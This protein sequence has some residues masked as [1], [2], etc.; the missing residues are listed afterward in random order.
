MA[1]SSIAS[2][3][4]A[5][6][7]PSRAAAG[8]ATRSPRWTASTAR[9][10]TATSASC[11]S[12]SPSCSSARRASTGR[13]TAR[14]PP[15][16]C[17]ATT[18]RA[19]TAIGVDHIMWG[20]DYPHM[21]GTFPFSRE[22][23]QMTFEGVPTTRSRRCSAATPPRIYGFDLD[24]LAPIAAECGP[25][26]SDVDA[27]LDRVPEGAREHGVLQVRWCRTS[28]AGRIRPAGCSGC[29]GT[30][31]SGPTRCLRACSRANF[32]GPNAGLD[33]A[34]AL[35]AD[36]VEVG[37]PG[38]PRLHR[39]RELACVRDVAARSSAGSAHIDR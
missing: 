10:P 15:A 36:E 25:L 31:S 18:A 38:R 14:S 39:C 22:A 23:M 34:R 32:S 16:S 26:V 17:T 12:S 1:A 29:G 2:R 3:T 8:S 30:G 19:V 27:G 4:C 6:C 37:A 5:S 20:S 33:P 13:A 24:K 35:V 28:S 7:S 11:A 9:S 21:E